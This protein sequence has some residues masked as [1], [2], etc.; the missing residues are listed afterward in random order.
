ML[1]ESINEL[2]LRIKALVRRR[3]LERDLDDELRFHLAMREQ[4]L[5]ESGVAPEEARRAARLSLGNPVALQEETREVWKLPFLE[6]L[7]QDIRYGLRQLRRNPGFAAVAIITLGLGIGANT[8]I[9]SVID[10]VLLRPLPF[11]HSGRL[12]SVE[13]IDTVRGGILHGADYPD[14]FD[15]QRENRVLS[16]I[17]AFRNSD[18]TFT[19]VS[20]PQHLTG[21]IVTSG[22]FSTLGVAP[23]IGRAFE[24]QEEE[25]GHPVVILSHRLWQDVFHG[26]PRILG[27]VITLQSRGYT[28]V[29]VMP[30]GF[31]FPIT[32]P[33][34]EL[35]TTSSVDARGKDPA[36]EQRGDRLLDVVGRLK[37]GVSLAQAQADMSRIQANLQ[38]QHPESD[39][40]LGGVRLVP[41][42][43]HLVGNAR[44]ALLVLF[45]AVGL[46]LLIACANVASLLLARSMARQKEMAIRAALGAGRTRVLRQLLTESIILSL[47]GG[48]LGLLLAGWGTSGLTS[49]IP[50]DIPR[51]A[52]IGVNGSVFLF[53]SAVAVLTGILFGMIPALQSARVQLVAP[54]R[55]GSQRVSGGLRRHRLRSALVV[56]EMALAVALLVSAGLLIRSFARLEAVK[57]GFDPQ[58]LLTFSVDLPEARYTTEQQVKFYDR[59]LLRLDALPGVHQAGAIIPLPLS[60]RQILVDFSVVGHP[61]PPG[62]EASAALRSVS[63]GYF[64][65]MG[66]PLLEGRV[67][68]DQDTRNS[69]PVMVVNQAFAEKYLSGQDPVG[70]RVIPGASDHTVKQIPPYQVIGVVGNVRS[71]SLSKEPKPEYYVPYSQIMFGGYSIVVRAAMAPKSLASAVREVV[72]RMDPDVPLYHLKTMDQ[73]IGA[74]TSQTRFS[75]LLLSLFAGLALALTTVG[76]YGVVS[77]AVAQQT[78]ELGIRIALGAGPGEVLGQV[79]GS[80]ACIALIGIA[81]GTA[82]ALGATRLLRGLLYGVTATDPGTFVA[83]A[84]VLFAVAMLSCYVPARR[85]MRVDPVT[86]LKYE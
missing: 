45:V 19:G 38:A 44:P 27:R 2:W 11:P 69:A 78:H 24:P 65:L 57:P 76:L 68:D 86:A 23:E 71:S 46:V 82:G 48:A 84:F 79:L 37:A 4:K 54:L 50:R 49:L 31:H 21:E 64:H 16:G 33:P 61:T 12:V 42:L 74:S 81:C 51:I 25:A 85:A 53:T 63:T 9:F 6:T 30:A 3:R 55:E 18:F 83:V 41:E 5:V 43:Q 8:A 28:V 13:T 1:P 80:G 34:V 52:Q 15:W 36:T 72:H 32:A 59:L 77:Y 62:N 20:Q 56:F 10:T 75:M 58:H 39:A 17:T 73:Y 35:W 26:D 67:F 40:D 14:F 66:I 70:Q 29:G 60:G 22:F 7:W 47:F